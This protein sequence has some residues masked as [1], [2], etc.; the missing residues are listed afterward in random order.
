[1]N[2]STINTASNDVMSSSH[3]NDLKSHG[4]DS[5]FSCN[6]CFEAVAEPVV[7]QCGHLY[8]WPCLY[9]W[10]EPGLLPDERDSLG[11]LPA[12]SADNSRRVCPVCKAAC[13][14]ATLVPIYVREQSSTAEQPA[15]PQSTNNDESNNVKSSLDDTENDVYQGDTSNLG[16]IETVDTNSSIDNPTAATGLRQRHVP[17]RPA[18]SSP[19][20]STPQTPS[21]PRGSRTGGSW[22][23]LTPNGH[24]ASLSHGI[25]LNFQQ[26]ASSSS[27]PPLHRREGENSELDAPNA[28][29]YLS[30]LLIMLTSFVLLCLLLL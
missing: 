27:V 20:H 17:S 18:P 2:N 15:G 16:Q 22:T 28:T 14:T 23:Q 26:A 3:R 12:I 21:T 30:R 5:R 19:R 24:R 11:L 1:M 13:S 29:E 25:M 8:C 6:I 10:I 9:R 4:V 7:T